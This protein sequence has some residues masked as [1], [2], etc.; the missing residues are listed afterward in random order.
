MWCRFQKFKYH[1]FIFLWKRDKRLSDFTFRQ[2]F[3]FTP[4]SN[5]KLDKLS[6]RI[7]DLKKVLFQHMNN[8]LWEIGE[9]Y[10]FVMPYSLV[11]ILT[12]VGTIVTITIVDAIWYLKTGKV[13]LFP[14]WYNRTSKT[15]PPAT[16]QL[17]MLN[18][19]TCDISSLI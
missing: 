8:I 2:T 17:Q 10:H 18:R 1:I 14:T 15:T 19:W 6:L 16:N 7:P 9:K 11:I 4:H 12:V 5:D 3:N 13:R